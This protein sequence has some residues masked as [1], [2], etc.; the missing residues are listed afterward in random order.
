M[1]ER[2]YLS[3]TPTLR[4]RPQVSASVWLAGAFVGYILGFLSAAVW[5]AHP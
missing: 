1:P 3:Q 2:V 4:A 5:M